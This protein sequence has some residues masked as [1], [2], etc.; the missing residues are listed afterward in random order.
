MVNVYSKINLMFSFIYSQQVMVIINR[1]YRACVASSKIIIR[2]WFRWYSYQEASLRQAP[3]LFK[4]LWLIFDFPFYG[5]LFK[6]GSFGY[7]MNYHYLAQ[8]GE[9]KL[10][11]GSQLI[12]YLIYVVDDVIM[13]LISI[14]FASFSEMFLIIKWKL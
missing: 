3:L 1:K 13:R 5:E 14:F 7:F 9:F 6:R 11:E 12:K 2:I 10:D 4:W 8:H